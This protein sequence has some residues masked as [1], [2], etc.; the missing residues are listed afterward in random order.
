M[1]TRTLTFATLSCGAVLMAAFAPA[2]G[3]GPRGGAPGKGDRAEFAKKMEAAHQNVL[4]RLNLTP[5]QTQEVAALDKKR[6]E[7]LKALREKNA[8]QG[9]DGAAPRR[10]EMRK[11]QQD[12]R[13]G[14][15]RILGPDKSKQYRELMREEMQKQG[16]GQRRQGGKPGGA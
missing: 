12:Y 4:K 10:E 6:A 1:K 11:I 13:A 15:E 16:L 8:G 7:Q 14:L 2:Q 9:R 3:A 5:K